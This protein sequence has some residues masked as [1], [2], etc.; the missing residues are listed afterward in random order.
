MSGT[1]KW[2][3]RPHDTKKNVEVLSRQHKSGFT[4]RV[5]CERSK[6]RYWWE[7][8]MGDIYEGGWANGIMAAKTMASVAASHHTVFK[9]GM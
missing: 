2:M 5:F 7:C 8:E 6:N 3:S 1:Q 4:L 9:P